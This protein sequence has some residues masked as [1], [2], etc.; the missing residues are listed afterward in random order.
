MQ[1]MIVRTSASGYDETTRSLVEAIERRGL[2]LFARIDHAAGAREVGLELASEQVLLFGNARS[3]T[4]LMQSD[5]R[6]GIELPL[7]ILIWQ[8]GQD[9][10]VGYRDPRE[11]AG[12]YEIGSHQPVLE[13]MAT[14]LDELAAEG[15]GEAR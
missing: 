5:P 13:Q 15:S 1:S 6:I 14:L 10:M 11:L 7:R 8:D 3:G 4:P 12:A 2:T 9:V